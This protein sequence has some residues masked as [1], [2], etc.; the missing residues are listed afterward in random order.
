MSTMTIHSRNPDDRVSMCV[1]TYTKEEHGLD[2]ESMVI[3]FAGSDVMLFFRDHQSV[4]ESLGSIIN[5]A[6]AYLDKCAVNSS[7][8][9]SNGV[10]ERELDVEWSHQ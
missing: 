8:R 2:F 9:D 3:E 5:S 7:F 1:N 10:D 6:Q 4:I